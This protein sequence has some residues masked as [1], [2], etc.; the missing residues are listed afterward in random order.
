MGNILVDGEIYIKTKPHFIYPDN[1][2]L[3]KIEQEL[4]DIKFIEADKGITKET[5]QK[6]ELLLHLKK[7]LST[8]GIL[9]STKNHRG[10][11]P[12]IKTHS[13]TSGSLPLLRMLRE[14][15][16]FKEKP[17]DIFFMLFFFL[18]PN[19]FASSIPIPSNFKI[20]T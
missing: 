14:L 7:T 2:K 3:K 11:P 5:L 17:S 18:L 15:S 8:I 12:Y 16:P 20:L 6:K 1:E 9:T 10:K 19:S 4:Y 13:F